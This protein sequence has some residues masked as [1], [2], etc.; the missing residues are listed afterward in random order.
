MCDISEGDC[1]AKVNYTDVYVNGLVTFAGISSLGND[2]P[3]NSINDT[4]SFQA[5]TYQRVLD[6]V[7]VV[8]YLLI[9]AFGLVGNG[10]VIYVVVVYAKMKTVTNM[11]I[12]NLAISDILFLTMLPITATTVL[13]K[14]WMFGLVMC[15]MYFVM[16]TLNVFGGALNLC[17]MSADRYLAVC[18]PIRSMK[19]RTPRI[20]L[21]LCLGV[22]FP[23]FLLMLPIILYTTTIDHPTRKGKYSCR[24]EWPEEHIFLPGQEF[25][26]YSFILGFVIPLSFISIF[27]VLVIFRLRRMRAAKKSKDNRRSHGRV[28]RLISTVITVYVVCWLPYWC[29]QV[30]RTTRDEKNLNYSMVL[31]MNAFTVLSYA[32]S[33]LNPFLYAF[34]GDNFRQSFA[35]AFKCLY[36]K[37]NVRNVANEKSFKHGSSQ[38]CLRPGASVAAEK[39][40]LSAI[41]NSSDSTPVMNQ[42]YSKVREDECGFLMP[43]IQL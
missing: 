24:V 41:D 14:H 39:I 42:I 26:L 29:F 23:S 28:T 40:E 1:Q 32:N 12:L 3:G 10:L 5:P 16:C 9:C 11:Y 21:C 35:K 43:P 38:S 18:Q 36:S 17:L 19:Y 34:L 8:C 27:Y 20:A 13:V 15:K 37:N 2:L 7:N 31:L 33:M 6:Y 30:H 4:H 22:W 25:V